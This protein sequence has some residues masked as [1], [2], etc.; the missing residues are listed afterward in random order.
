MNP[1]ISHSAPEIPD[2][3]HSLPDIAS[4]ESHRKMAPNACQAIPLNGYQEPHPWIC[5]ILFDEAASFRCPGYFTEYG[6]NVPGKMIS[7][8]DP[9]STVFSLLVPAELYHEVRQNLTGEVPISFPDMRNDVAFPLGHW[10]EGDMAVFPAIVE[11]EE[12][13][14]LR[15]SITR[16]GGKV[17]KLKVGYLIFTRPPNQAER[18]VFFK[19]LGCDPGIWFVMLEFPEG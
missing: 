8:I 10:S 18:L 19:K 13:D 16:V 5:A 11:N 14:I 12:Q 17:R 7:G 3:S 2:P 6:G 1:D 9:G 4:G 15:S